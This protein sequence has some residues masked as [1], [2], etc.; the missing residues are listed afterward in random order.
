MVSRMLW[1][2]R[3]SEMPGDVTARQKPASTPSLL[4]WACVYGG[5]LSLLG[6]GLLL[7]ML[8]IPW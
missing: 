1:K 4:P 7:R 2:R 8:L 3:A 5:L 6:W